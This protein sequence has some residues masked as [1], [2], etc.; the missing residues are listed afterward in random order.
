MGVFFY[1]STFSDPV[2]DISIIFT[3]E[4]DPRNPSKPVVRHNNAIN[5]IGSQ[6][7]Y[8]SMTNPMVGNTDPTKVKEGVIL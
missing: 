5:R 6:P 3:P 4:A 2:H 7:R 8:A 1:A